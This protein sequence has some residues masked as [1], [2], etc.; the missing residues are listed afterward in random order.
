[1]E[2]PPAFTFTIVGAAGSGKSYLTSALSGS[3]PDG[4]ST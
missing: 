4:S 2:A 1:M 3:L